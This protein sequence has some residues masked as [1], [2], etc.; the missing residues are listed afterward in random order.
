MLRELKNDRQNKGDRHRRWFKDEQLE[1]IL[2]YDDERKLDGF[3]ICYDKLAASR[4]ITWKK[5]TTSEGESKS[6][7]TSD[8]PFDR[9]RLYYMIDSRSDRLGSPLKQFIL[10]RLESNGG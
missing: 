3:Q 4:L 8:S 7:L 6:I 9:E 2:W 5:I 10:D 1:I